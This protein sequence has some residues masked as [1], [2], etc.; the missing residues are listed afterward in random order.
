MAS[1][2]GQHLYSENRYSWLTEWSLK[3]CE[4]DVWYKTGYVP[5]DWALE[6][7]NPAA[8]IGET[9]G[10]VPPNRDKDDPLP[11]PAS[12]TITG[13]VRP[14]GAITGKVGTT[15]TI[16]GVVRPVGHLSG[17][18]IPEV[19]GTITGLLRPVGDITGKAVPPGAQGTIVG[20]VRP[21]GNLV[22]VFTAPPPWTPALLDATVLKLWLKASDLS[23]IISA[24]GAVSQWNDKSGN[25]NNLTQA[26]GARQPTT[27]T[28]TIN[29][30]NTLS[31]DGGDTLTRLSGVTLPDA[32]GAGFT[33]LAVMAF[34][35]NPANG[36]ILFPT[37]AAASD[38]S[39][40][41][42]RNG[43]NNFGIRSYQGTV[44]TEAGFTDSTTV[45][46]LVSSICTTTLRQI[47]QNGTS[48][49]TSVVAD[50]TPHPAG[51]IYLGADN[52]PTTFITGR[53]AEVLVIVGVDA[54]IRQKAEGYLAWEHGLVSDLAAGHPYKLTYPTA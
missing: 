2:Y 23:T 11:L 33:A 1:V 50:A 37:N 22:G 16:A 15:G 27:G 9:C 5:Q 41:F 38:Y 53:I 54:T 51:R 42:G 47:W 13:V 36:H 6:V 3:P 35:G 19:K 46:E 44:P 25:L 4:P 31:F 34:T 10:P 28:T 45:P 12:G 14:V 49:G 29:G 39:W 40:S 26:T 32:S 43:V 20:T 48:R 18:F 8:W 21:I 52:N 17:V 30:K 24:L 7:C